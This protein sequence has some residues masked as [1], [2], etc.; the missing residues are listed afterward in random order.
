MT[1][2]DG[3][4]S[5]WRC[6]LCNTRHSV[7]PIRWTYFTPSTLS[8]EATERALRDDKAAGFQQVDL[9]P[10]EKPGVAFKDEEWA[11]CQPCHELI[12]DGSLEALVAR[13]IAQQEGSYVIIGLATDDNDPLAR[14]LAEARS[15]AVKIIAT[16]WTH[17]SGAPQPFEG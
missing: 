7:S 17:R 13:C 9:L 4:P 1:E 15:Q 6:D 10:G 8:P 11:V 2:P 12:C 3:D 16:F 5:Q 14:M